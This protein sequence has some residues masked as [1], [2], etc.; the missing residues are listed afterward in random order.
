V[1]PG[2][3]PRIHHRQITLE[4]KNATCP[5]KTGAG[6]IYIKENSMNKIFRKVLTVLAAGGLALGAF[7]SLA[8]ADE[9]ERP[10]ADLNIAFLSKY[11]WRG[12]ELSKDSL[13]I[14]PSLTAA[15]MGFGF[16]LWGNLDTNQDTGL[17]DED[18]VAWNE[19]DMTISYD[20]SAGMMNYSFG[21]IYY[22]IDIIEDTQEIY[23]AVSLDTILAPTLT[24]YRNV[25]NYLGWYTTLGVSHSFK[26]PETITLDL[27]GYVSYWSI[28]KAATLSDPDD[29]TESFSNF[30]DGQVSLSLSIP[31]TKYISVTPQLYY[32][33]PLSSAA[34]DVLKAAS[35]SGDDDSYVYGGI[36][37]NMA[38]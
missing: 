30:Y 22:G 24:V 32:S 2:S 15:Y 10:S 27:G 18:G 12:F 13:V 36:S 35:S 23:G 3:V 25:S 14:Q 1:R 20:N 19:T 37:F 16:N 4:P 5:G 28:D 17:F 8:L 29:S 11:V 7:T 34:S 38:F 26:L 9:T 6:P 33:F 21:Y 31:V